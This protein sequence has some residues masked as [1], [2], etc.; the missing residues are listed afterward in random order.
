MNELI[1]M[2]KNEQMRNSSPINV[3]IKNINAFHHSLQ[4]LPPNI[5]NL[6]SNSRFGLIGNSYKFN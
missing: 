4:S 6:S 2:N 1:E 5:I 3:S